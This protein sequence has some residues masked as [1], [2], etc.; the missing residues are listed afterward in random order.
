MHE[1]RSS[2]TR[3]ADY[4]VPVDARRVMAAAAES[5]L[6]TT[7]DLDRPGPTIVYVNP[8]FERMTG[9]QRSE[10]LGLSPRV[11][12]GPE[13]DHRI[14]ADLRATL[15]RGE[16]W[17]GQAINYRKD[18]STFVM[19]WSVTPLE[20]ADGAVRH[21]LA[22]QRD[23][24]AR[25]TAEREAAAA[26]AAEAR[27]ERA[28]HNLA[29]YFP[30]RLVED[31]SRQDQP[32]GPVR[33]QKL[34][35]MF[36]DLVGF[37]RLAERSDP[38]DVVGLLREFHSRVARIVFDHGGS[39][40]AYVGDAVVAVFGVPEPSLD[41]AG[42]ALAAAVAVLD[43]LDDWTADRRGT[44]LP[45]VA[46]GIGLNYGPAVLAD[47]GSAEHLAFTVI[48]DTMNTAS[49]LQGMTR[50]LG[51]QVAVGGPLVDAMRAV[52]AGVGPLQNLRDLGERVI[53]GRSRPVRVWAL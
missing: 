44:G 11:L 48:G 25:V 29:R 21:Y 8:A 34:A 42:N 36:V 4:D 5:L 3:L 2:H 31:L 9:W 10:I 28:R 1:Q 39:V 16:T 18:G 52:P 37:T 17:T 35:A 13:T 46:V 38:A 23:V 6:I 45:P 20:D 47:V 27:S 26:R 53:R 22:V 51:C 7:T 19:E 14:F 49:R 32:L 33:R 50:E 24:T 43:D 15:H 12:Q 40:E 30:P 41:D